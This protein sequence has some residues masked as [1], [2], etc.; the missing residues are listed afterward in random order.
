[1]ETEMNGKQTGRRFEGKTV[2]I[3]GAARGQGRSHAV[4]FAEEGANIVACDICA[5]LPS[6]QYQMATPDDLAETVRLVEGTDQRIVAEEADVC[7]IDAIER[8]IEHGVAE[9]GPIDIVVANAGVAGFLGPSWEMPQQSWDDVLGTNLMGAWNL[10]KAV[11]PAMIERDAGGSLIFIASMGG[12]RSFIN[13]ADYTIS[14][15]GMI[16]LM[17]AMAQELGKHGIRSNA[18]CP[19]A[20][21][22]GI[23]INDP[24]KRAFFPDRDPAGLSEEEFGDLIQPIFNLLPT[25]FIE[26]EDISSAVLWLASEE[27]RYVTGVALPVDAGA[28]EKIG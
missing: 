22:T 2:L 19:T 14:K 8:V 1:M 9:F 24:V 5:Q 20:V 6:V 18:V 15:H 7:D 13:M 10:A 16:G 3:S 21:R 28:L 4:R 12:L 17:R 27:A 23:M 26:P 25:G 11:I